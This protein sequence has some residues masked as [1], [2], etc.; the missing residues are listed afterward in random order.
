LAAE[1]PLAT[2]SYLKEGVRQLCMQPAKETAAKVLQDW[3]GRD[4]A[5]GIKVLQ[6]LAET[7]ALYRTGILAHH[8]CHF[9][10]G[11]L[12]GANNKVKTIRSVWQPTLISRLILKVTRQAHGFRGK[13]SSGSRS[14]PSARPNALYSDEPL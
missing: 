14:W 10:T 2:A 3:I 6:T 4:E 1:E 8:D 12:E 5:S 11:R 13:R 7:P 9:V